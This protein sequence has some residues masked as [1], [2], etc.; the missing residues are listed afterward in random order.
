MKTGEI[1]LIPLGIGEGAEPLRN[2]LAGHDFLEPRHLDNDT[3]LNLHYS[4][5]DLV[6]HPSRA[7]TSSMVGL[8]AMASGTP[9]VAARVGGVPEVI[10]DGIGGVLIDPESPEQLASETDSLFA[11]PQRL[12]ALST[13][14]R[15]RAVEEF[16]VDR[17]LDAHEELYRSVLD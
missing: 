4:A 5:A 16:G 7:D 6:W 2:F 8:E 15:R 13:S 12:A 14:A 1:T 10:G 17:F 9:V 11:D 3:D